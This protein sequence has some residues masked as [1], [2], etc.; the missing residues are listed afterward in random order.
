MTQRL[1]KINKS[2]NEIGSRPKLEPWQ[3]R[4]QSL[5]KKYNETS[6]LDKMGVSTIAFGDI[7]HFRILT[8]SKLWLP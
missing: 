4:A 8:E 1:D 7:S 2:H 3:K 6:S 5:T